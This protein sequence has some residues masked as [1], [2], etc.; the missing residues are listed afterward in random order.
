MQYKKL[1]FL[2]FLFTVI[3]LFFN[4]LTGFSQANTTQTSPKS[5]QENFENIY[6]HWGIA[7][8]KARISKG[9]SH[10]EFDIFTRFSEKA[11]DSLR[12]DFIKR[13]SDGKVTTTN[14]G[15]YESVLINSILSLYGKY[16]AI[17]ILYPSSVEEYR[18]STLSKQLAAAPCSSACN[19]IDFATGNLSGWNA[20][21]AFNASATSFNITNITGGPAGAVTH[22]AN[23][24]LTST[25]GYYNAAAGVPPNPR[26][27]Y[28]INITS[29]SRG[30]AIVPT[31]PVVSPFG[32]AYSVMLGDSTQVN[33]GIAILSQTFLVTPSNENL[34]YQY[35]VF[36][37]NPLHA[38]YQQPFFSITL[39]DQAGD[40]IPNCGE[41]NVV[42]GN[43]TQSFDSVTNYQSTIIANDIYTVY[44][45]NWTIVNVPLKKY[46]R[47]CVTIV[48]EAADC[49]AGG[50][51][52]YAYVDAS[53]SPN[54]VISSSP[55]LCGQDSITLTAPPGGASYIWTGPPNSII[56]SST[57]QTIAADSAG[58]YRVIVVPVTGFACADTLYDTVGKVPGPPP[59][60]DFYATNTCAGEITHFINTSTDTATATFY[61]DFYNIG[62]Y[63]DSGIVNPTWTYATPGTYEVKLDEVYNGCG[64][65]TVIKIH[66]S[67]PVTGDFTASNACIG[68]VVNA[69]SNLTGATAYSWNY[70]DPASG[71][72]NS[73]SGINGSHT[74]TTAGT[75]TITL[76]GTNGGT[77]P[78]TATQVVHIYPIPKPIITGKDSVCPNY[79]D[80]L[81]VTGGTTYLW[82]TGATTTS[83][84]N[85]SAITETISVT[86]YNGT[87][88]HD[89][90][91]I[92]Y[93]VS[94]TPVIT[95]SKTSVCAGDTVLLT[96]SGS[97][98]YRWSNNSTASSIIVTPT[99]PSTYTVYT[100][101]GDCIDSATVTITILQAVTCT[102]T[103][104]QDSVCKGSSTTI[105]VTA[106][107]GH[108][109][110]YHWSTGQTGP[111]ITQSPTSNTTYS[112]TV[113]NGFCSFDTSIFIYVKIAPIL[114][115]V[116][117]VDTI[118]IGSSV[119]LGVSGGHSY[120][121]T[122]S[123]SLSCNTCTNPTATPTISTTYIVTG[124]DTDGCSE[125]KNV[126]V[127][128][129]TPP[130]ID[131]IAN[132]TTCAGN[133]V[134]LFA[135]ELSGFNGGFTW[136]PGNE[137]GP[138]ITIFPDSTVTYTVQ[139]ANTCGTAS[140]NV[141]VFVNPSPTPN[142]TAD[143]IQGCA[144]L[145]IE[146]TDLSTI[147]S[148]GNI[149]LWSWNFGDGDS[150]NEQ[151]PLYCYPDTGIFTVSLTTVSNNGCS[152]TLK[153]DQMITVYTKPI[154]NFTYTPAEPISILEPAVQLTDESTDKY[155]LIYWFWTF[156]DGT[157]L[158]Y[159]D[160]T[161]RDPNHIYQDTGWFCPQLIVENNKGC[162]DTTT[163]CLYI[164]PIFTLYIPSAFTPNGD[165]VDDT[166]EPKGVYVKNFEMYIFDRWGEELYHTTN[167]YQGWDGTV[168]GGTRISQEDSYVYKITAT[169]WWDIRHSYIGEFTLIK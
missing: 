157:G 137:T 78:D 19:N 117:P 140:S 133:P 101:I 104:S 40:T 63:N 6:L 162:V 109:F 88:S 106:S 37:A 43:G 126:F 8:D 35:A 130:F 39:L 138:S 31:V 34:T 116:S 76:I 152:A 18:H 42:S 142:F 84:I 24:T 48:F 155:G 161:V 11:M 53:C 77:C 30:D 164:D 132:Q 61:W 102:V 75:Y 41:Y 50:H 81:K 7:E 123:N 16:E 147:S 83:I 115:V 74:Y 158:P 135:D 12:A 56:G 139:Y 100:T 93:R 92:I 151:N 2:S 89:T 20:Y 98:N 33:Y 22:A 5:G 49:A 4:S 46:L 111:S 114:V 64:V 134:T 94:L 154:A 87:C 15:K 66:I 47:Q 68:S 67:A 3:L 85:A 86:A 27:D 28:Q 112:V 96:A 45:K 167:I 1:L 122:P 148:I 82:S 159:L 107:G 26:P 136:E 25:T 57:S 70:G 125:S 163:Q 38:Y 97:T 79:N 91:F 58:V 32:G 169:D 29:G 108:N 72:L 90:A 127:L 113:S 95:A 10:E 165:G 55:N 52:G 120:T 23:D 54:G 145:C 44:Y 160:D 149:T 166:F 105:T 128:V 80:T 110:T 119:A 156:G 131:T 62:V 69:T 99:V 143:V 60:P 153:I 146:F 21:Y 36:L 150:A 168:H 118:C 121:W 65:D 73:S 71:P 124:Y 51:F 9:I 17:A 141:T 59:K 13:I 129:D 103:V 144:P 14:I